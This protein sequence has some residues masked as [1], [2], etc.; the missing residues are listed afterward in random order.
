MCC[1]LHSRARPASTTRSFEPTSTATSIR[2]LRL[3]TELPGDRGLLDTSVVVALGT[4]ERTLLPEEIAVS[5][6]TLAELAGGPHGAKHELERARRQSHLQ[7][8]EANLEP[9]A[10]DPRCAR[11]F[12]SVY[13]AI[14]SAG[15]KPRGA[16]AVD[17]MIAATAIANE[18]P[19]YTLNPKDLRGLEGLIEIVDVGA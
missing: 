17:L 11:A 7:Y 3:A 5:A 10:F 13:A 6:L 4:I 8:V 16:R 12:G 14:A 18:L 9:L 15:R 19:L 1:L 2:T